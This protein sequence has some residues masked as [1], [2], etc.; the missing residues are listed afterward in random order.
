[1]GYLAVLLS[2]AAIAIACSEQPA[3]APF[4]VG[5]SAD[6]ALTGEGSAIRFSEITDAAFIGPK[7]LIVLDRVRARLTLVQSGVG[8]KS[9]RLRDSTT[10]ALLLAAIQGDSVAVWDAFANSIT[11]V[12]GALG[13]IGRTTTDVP[14]FQTVVGI[15]S[16]AVPV[17]AAVRPLGVSVPGEYVPDSAQLAAWEGESRS[18]SGAIPQW[19]TIRLR[20]GT[21]SA[22]VGPIWARRGQAQARGDVVWVGDGAIPSIMRVDRNGQSATISLPVERLSGDRQA[23]IERRVSLLPDELHDSAL[24]L[25][26]RWAVDLSPPYFSSFRVD[27]LERLWIRLPSRAH[28]DSAAWIVHGRAAQPLAQLKL[29]ARWR[30]L[31]ANT[32]HAAFAVSE[33]TGADILLLLPLERLP[34]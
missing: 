23:E 15:L 19:P 4:A 12:D 6:S 8:I 21:A 27:A 30:L 32:T 33:P 13:A 28:S 29:P 7:S 34:Q 22:P 10:A 18:L 11:V 31:D 24:S 14:D 20:V 1:L 25:F 5:A 26:K 17:I 3:D 2:G 9:L 16:D